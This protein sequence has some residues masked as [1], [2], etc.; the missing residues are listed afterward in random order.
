MGLWPEKKKRITKGWKKLYEDKIN[1]VWVPLNLKL[2]SPRRIIIKKYVNIRGNKSYDLNI[3]KEKNMRGYIELQKSFETKK[4]ALK[5][6]KSYMK[7]RSK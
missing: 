3:I 4:D 1:V 6:A 7:R 5:Y 2:N